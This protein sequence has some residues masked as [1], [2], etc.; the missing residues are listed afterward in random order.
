MSF[1]LRFVKN[2]KLQ[3][4]ARIKSINTTPSERLVAERTLVKLVQVQEF[5]DDLHSLKVFNRVKSGS[6]LSALNPFIDNYGVLRVGGRLKNCNQNFDFKHPIL[7]PK[8]HPFTNLLIRYEHERN[9]HTGLEATLSFI[10]RKYWPLSGREAV[11]SIIRQCIPCFKT[12]PPIINS[13]MGNLPSM[14]VTPSRAFFNCGIDYSGP[15]LLKDGKYRNRKILKCY[16]CIFICLSTK[17]IHIELASELTSECFIAALRRFVS[18]RGIC[19][20]IY[21]DNGSNFVGADK[22]LKYIIRILK[23]Q[24]FQR[25]VNTINIHWHFTP[26]CS[27]HFGGIWEAAIKSVKRHLKCVI[28]TS[29]FTFEEFY[30]ILTQVEAVLNSRPLVPMSSDPNDL[31]VITP[32]HFL[33]GEPLNLLPEVDVTEISSNN[34][35]RYKHLQKITQQFWS[36]WSKDYLHNL[37]QRSK[38]RFQ[39][40]QNDIIGKLVLLREDNLPPSQWVLGRI[41]NVHPGTDGIV[42]VVSVSTKNGVIKRSTVKI[43]ILPIN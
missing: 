19:S 23:D 9:L 40:H 37:H 15:F 17:A 5:S 28:N 21:S 31:G 34:L 2:T 26:P 12:N 4:E 18:R 30:T 35:S 1:C 27:P 25:F 39:N 7:I 41:T 14:R 24:K 8:R 13:Q 29:L 32:S 20:H 22:E 38:W 10:R 43:S 11:R 16:M 3:P 36:R 33:I 6:K 42:R